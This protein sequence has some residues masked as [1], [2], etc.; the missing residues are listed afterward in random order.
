MIKSLISLAFLLVLQ[1]AAFCQQKSNQNTVPVTPVQQKQE[2][3][4]VSKTTGNVVLPL[5]A[6]EYTDPNY[7]ANKTLSEQVNKNLEAFPEAGP[8]KQEKIAY[9]E[10]QIGLMKKGTISNE[11]LEAYE[12][13]LFG[14]KNNQ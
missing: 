4:T 7:Q 8:T 13:E 6:T 3:T 11:K 12:A 10:K 5:P 14:L 2:N 9:L 1:H